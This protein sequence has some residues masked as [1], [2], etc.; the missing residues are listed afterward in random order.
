LAGLSLLPD[1]RT[2]SRWLGRFNRQ[3]LRALATI[4]HRIVFG[5]IRKLGLRTVT[6]DLD[7][8][9]ISTGLQTECPSSAS[10]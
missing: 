3:S 6:V 10:G 2:V 1:E 8:T 5:S 9:V 4:N 7:G